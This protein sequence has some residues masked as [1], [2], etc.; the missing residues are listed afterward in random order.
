MTSEKQRCS[1]KCGG[2][3]CDGKCGTNSSSCSG[4]VDTY[5]NVIEIRKKFDEMYNKQELIFKRILTKVTQSFK[6]KWITL[7]KLNFIY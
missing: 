2:A 3:G 1:A 5:W 7:I 4:L 6:K